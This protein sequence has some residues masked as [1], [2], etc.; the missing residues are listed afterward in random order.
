MN[1]KDKKTKKYIIATIVAAIGIGI[2]TNAQIDFARNVQVSVVSTLSNLKQNILEKKDLLL[3][4]EK[5]VK[6]TESEEGKFSQMESQIKKIEN[7]DCFDDSK[8]NEN[9]AMFD[10]FNKELDK[11]MT[12]YNNNSAIDE[13]VLLVN[14]REE[15]KMLNNFVDEMMFE[16]NKDYLPEFNK[17]IATFPAS[18][19][20]NSKDWNKVNEFK[21]IDMNKK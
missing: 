13:D 19:Y 12:L 18:I 1:L 8:I 2:F 10:N 20:A 17:R 7:A 16:Y 9:V 5:E 3:D 14:K 11:I 4:I 6:E 15:V 21:S